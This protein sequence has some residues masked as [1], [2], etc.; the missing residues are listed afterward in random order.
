MLISDEYRQVLE[1]EYEKDP[2][3]GYTGFKYVSYMTEICT[4]GGFS[5]LLD[6][7]CGSGQF[8]IK[9]LEANPDIQLFEY[10]P[11]I[12][13]K[14]HDP[15]SAEVVLCSDVL[16]HVEPVCLDDVLRHLA[17][18]ARKIAVLGIATRPSSQILADGRNAH[19][20]IED[21]EWW[22]SK[23]V[24]YFSVLRQTSKPQFTLIIAQP[25]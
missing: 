12:P 8:G 24:Q 20:I 18:K 23:I 6:Y 14:S 16:E 21:A 1:N 25:R 10:D 9:F 15:E 5:S 22:V 17:S 3:F 13:E 19:L 2:R 11:A 7:G 4:S